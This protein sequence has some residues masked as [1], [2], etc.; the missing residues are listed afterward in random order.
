ME[1]RIKISGIV[2]LKEVYTH[3]KNRCYYAVLS[4]TAEVKGTNRYFP[5]KVNLDVPI[6]A[7]QYEELGKKLSESKAEKP[8]LRVSGELELILDSVCIN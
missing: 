6:T 4:A 1:P 7:E 2:S 3:P 5:P 8:V